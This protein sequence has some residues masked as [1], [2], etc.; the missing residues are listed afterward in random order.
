MYL[1]QFEDLWK[2]FTAV[3]ALLALPKFPHQLLRRHLGCTDFHQFDNIHISIQVITIPHGLHRNEAI[4]AGTFLK[5]CILLQ[6][7]SWPAISGIV[8]YKLIQ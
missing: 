6:I 2:M 4:P 8:I 3:N 7:E 5:S 1:E